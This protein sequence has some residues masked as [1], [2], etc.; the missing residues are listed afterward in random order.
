MSSSHEETKKEPIFHLDKIEI[1]TLPRMKVAVFD[2][3]SN[4][5]EQ[6]VGDMAKKWLADHGVAI[7]DVSARL[8]GF[9][10]YTPEEMMNG[11][12]RYTMYATVPPSLS[13]DDEDNVKMFNGGRYARLMIED[14][15]TGDFPGGWGLLIDWVRKNGYRDKG[16]TCQI[17]GIKGRCWRSSEENPRP[18]DGGCWGSS[19]LSPCFEEIVTRNGVQYMDFYLPIV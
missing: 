9:D 6:K 17:K 10:N 16:V 1:I 13:V 7:D 8:L 18:C 4:E 15:F 3:M 2:K 12:R 14:P 5:P 11:R 19:E